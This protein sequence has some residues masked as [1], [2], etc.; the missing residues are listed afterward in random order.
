MV[1]EWLGKN[2][3][4]VAK[5]SSDSKSSSDSSSSSNYSDSCIEQNMRFNFN[6][7]NSVTGMIFKSFL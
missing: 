6:N 4:Q 3:V 7:K 2:C 5:K 1:K